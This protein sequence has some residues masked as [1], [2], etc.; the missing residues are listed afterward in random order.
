LPGKSRGWRSLVGYSPWSHRELDSTEQ[1][2]F[3][4][5]FHVWMCDLDCKESWAPKNWFFWIVVLYK[6]LALEKEMATH[7]SILAWRIPM[8]RGT[9]QATVHGVTRVGHDLVTKPSLPP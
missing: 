3:H 8:D 2:D 1:L 6:T 4:F 5:H 7:Y 9:W